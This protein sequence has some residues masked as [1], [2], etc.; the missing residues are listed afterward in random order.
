MNLRNI[1]AHD[2]YR[3]SEQVNHTSG[4]YAR[5]KHRKVGEYRD[6]PLPARARRTIEWYAEKHGTTDGYLLRH[7]KD[8]SK[9][10][11]YYHLGNR[12]LRIKKADEVEIPKG[13]VLYGM[14]HFPATGLQSVVSQGLTAGDFGDMPSS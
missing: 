8:S 13:M 6:A 3:I 5:L 14:R 10:F 1:V 9:P 11:P 12:W 7:P 4:Q 2:V